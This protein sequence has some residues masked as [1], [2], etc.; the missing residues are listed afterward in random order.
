M[1]NKILKLFTFLY[2]IILVSCGIAPSKTLPNSNTDY[3]DIIGTTIKVDNL[4]V[5]QYDFPN[6]MNWDDAKKAATELG[7][8][9]RLPDKDELE[10]LYENKNK[11]GWFSDGKYWSLTE[12]YFNRKPLLA[13]YHDFGR[14]F[15]GNESKEGMHYVRF[16]KS[17]SQVYFPKK[18]SFQ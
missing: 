2:L 16:V 10:L 11:I 1:K 9:W 15:Q 13:W 12:D 8:G 17:K 18:A 7:K 4:E 14:G 5:A 3:E 6:K